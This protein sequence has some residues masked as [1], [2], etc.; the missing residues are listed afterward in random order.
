M[1]HKGIT[2]QECQL[3]CLENEE[4]AAYS[5]IKSKKWCFPKHGKGNVKADLDVL[6]GV[7]IG[8]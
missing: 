4:C 6:S 2:S 3:I 1:G 8:F 7:K 5:Y